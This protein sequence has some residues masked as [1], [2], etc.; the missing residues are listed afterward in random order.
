MIARPP[1]EPSE[2]P[3]RRDGSAAAF[4]AEDGVSH[5]MIRRRPFRIVLLV[6]VVVGV[7]V[8]VAIAATS[9][10]IVSPLSTAIVVAVDRDDPRHGVDFHRA[11]TMPY[12]D[13]DEDDDDD[14]DDND[15][16]EEKV[17]ERNDDRVADEG[18]RSLLS[19]PNP[20]SASSTTSKTT[21]SIRCPEGFRVQTPD[22]GGDGGGSKQRQQP[23]MAGIDDDRPYLRQSMTYAASFPGSG[24]RMIT[25]YLVEGM[26][27]LR[28]VEAPSSF[29]GMNGTEGDGGEPPHPSESTGG[30]GRKGGAGRGREKAGIAVRTQWPH[31]S[32]RLAS[33][34]EDIHRAFVVLRS[35]LHAIPCHFDRM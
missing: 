21:T 32:G 1:A 4:A 5:A 26:T 29:A 16:E 31:T 6:L 8:A 24:D 12:G 7:G 18:R 19:S 22:G 25:K 9:M 27:G 10:L 13:G 23:P 14:D 28:V 34:D 30:R 17:D 11:E 2:P 20:P 15:K 35:P 3:P 33:W